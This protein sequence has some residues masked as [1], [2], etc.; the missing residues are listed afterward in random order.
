MS[1]YLFYKEN[2]YNETQYKKR[3]FS[4]LHSRSFGRIGSFDRIWMD[5]TFE[6]TSIWKNLGLKIL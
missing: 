2:I 6:K 3:H 4:A 5:L 1:T